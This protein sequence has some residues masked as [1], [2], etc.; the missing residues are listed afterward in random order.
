MRILSFDISASPGIAVIEVKDAGTPKAKPRL[1]SVDH[2]ETDSDHT[3]AQRYD[4][5]QAFVTQFVHENGSYDA[6][7]REKFIRGG[8]KRSTQLVF[9]AWASVDRA[10]A[11][12]G[13]AIDDKDEIV[14]STVKRI[15]GGNGSAKKPA[16]AEGVIRILGEDSR[17]HFFTERGRLLDDRSDAVAIGLTYAIQ[18]GLIA[19]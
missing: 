5:V 3:D 19:D 2:I 18:K 13:Y 16:V 9:G 11:T 14:A 17:K 7:V 4:Y 6:I 12:Y 15:I 10:L 1:I 8:S